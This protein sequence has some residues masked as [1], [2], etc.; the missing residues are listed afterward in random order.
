MNTNTGVIRNLA[1]GEQP[2]AD[3]VLLTAAETARLESLPFH[4]RNGALEAMRKAE[5]ASRPGNS[6]GAKKRARP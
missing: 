1:I 3:E 6:R 4:E 2:T 5:L